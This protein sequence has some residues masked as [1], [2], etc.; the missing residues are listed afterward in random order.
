MRVNRNEIYKAVPLVFLMYDIGKVKGN[1]FCILV[2]PQGKWS[3][4]FGAN[5]TKKMEA[6]WLKMESELV[7]TKKS[8][9][10]DPKKQSKNL[11][12]CKICAAIHEAF[13]EHQK[14]YAGQVLF[15]HY[16]P[17]ENGLKSLL[18][19]LMS[20]TQVQKIYYLEQ[21]SA[22]YMMPPDQFIEKVQSD[23][24]KRVSIVEFFRL[25]DYGRFET[26]VLYEIFRHL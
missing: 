10:F 25:I 2:F 7:T 22:F 5:I 24:R 8:P 16:V 11:K 26:G 19:A 6:E 12:E 17:E 23:I 9:L 18:T 3:K 13:K 14:E 21:N 20:D 1:H 15:S 4:K